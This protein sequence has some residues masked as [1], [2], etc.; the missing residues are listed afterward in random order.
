MALHN[1]SDDCWVVVFGYVLDMTNLLA[2][3]R[4]EG[5]SEMCTPIEQAAGTDISHWMDPIT[6]EPKRAVDPS[7]NLFWWYCPTGRYLHIPP[8]TPD[9]EWDP[10]KIGTPWW[11]DDDLRIG[12]VTQKVRR[13]RLI[14]MI[15]KDDDYMDVC[16]EENIH[17]I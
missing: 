6:L 2:K 12:Q 7:F 15:T 8:I 16:M 4:E 3:S 17:E 1:T 5:L 10:E 14:N 9:S 11:R 13:V